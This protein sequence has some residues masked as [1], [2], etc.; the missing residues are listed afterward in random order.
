MSQHLLTC[1][2]GRQLPVELGQAGEQLRCECGTNISVPT[3]RQLR[4][5][6]VAAEVA[7]AQVAK[8]AWGARQGAIAASL[9]FVGLLL[10]GAGVSR[11]SEHPLPQFH[12]DAQIQMV[13][14]WLAKKS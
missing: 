3:L 7:P 4:Q 6:P 1:V 2:C 11:Y 14:Q 13:D 5:L 9:I 10:M 12:P 8:R